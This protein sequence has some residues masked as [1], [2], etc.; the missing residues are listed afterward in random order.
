MQSAE[1]NG[2]TEPTPEQRAETQKRHSVMQTLPQAPPTRIR[3]EARTRTDVGPLVSCKPSTGFRF[4]RCLTLPLGAL[5]SGF[6]KGHKVHSVVLVGLKVLAAACA[7]TY[8][9]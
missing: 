1:I 5:P 7:S 3:K 8:I 2:R 6:A 4:A 9:A